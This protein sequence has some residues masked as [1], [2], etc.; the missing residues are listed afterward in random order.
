MPLVMSSLRRLEPTADNAFT[1]ALMS[2]ISAKDTAKWLRVVLNCRLVGSFVLDRLPHLSVRTISGG[3]P[4]L[5]VRRGQIRFGP[6]VCQQLTE[7]W[8]DLDD[9]VRR[10]VAQEI[11]EKSAPHMASNSPPAHA[12]QL[13]AGAGESGRQPLRPESTRG[14][15]CQPAPCRPTS[16]QSHNFAPNSLYLSDSASASSYL[17]PVLDASRVATIEDENLAQCCRDFRL[18][19]HRCEG[20]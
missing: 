5:G 16:P 2:T 13:P 10:L 1:R 7:F 20:L 6:Y 9:I 8:V 19:Q 4:M 11:R 14:R 15:C 12:P 17:S 3:E 18:N